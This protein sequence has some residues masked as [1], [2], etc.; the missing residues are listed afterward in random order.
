[1]LVQPLVAPLL[2]A[3]AVAAGNDPG[4]PLDLQRP[5]GAIGRPVVP[6]QIEP[7]LLKG[8]RPD[9]ISEVSKFEA[10]K[11]DT[12]K[13]GTPEMPSKEPAKPLTASPAE[14]AKAPA[15]D[16]VRPEAQKTDKSKNDETKAEARRPQAKDQKKT[17]PRKDEQGD[18]ERTADG[19]PAAEDS[20]SDS[21][22]QDPQ[23]YCTNIAPTATDARIA[24]QAK[25]LSE[26]DAQIK[27]RIGDLEVK[28]AEFQDWLTRREEALKKAEDGVV[29]I[30]SRMRPDAAALQLSAMDDA[31]AAAV[32]VKLNP[33]AAS[34]I[35]NEMSAER[36]ARLTNAMSGPP[37]NADGK[38]L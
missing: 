33:R 34:A 5:A 38:K 1:M 37:A 23:S 21:H 7:K 32:L 30:Y 9:P 19:H 12:R 4:P 14:A 35:L 26:L 20:K 17:D 36:A 8:R 16:T 3:A 18:E 28:R 24:W 29:A 22:A 13:A 25:R 31:T 27:Q 10:A 15:P 11:P 6:R 2:W